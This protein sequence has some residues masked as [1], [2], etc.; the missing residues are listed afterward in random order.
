V[1]VSERETARERESQSESERVRAR[2]RETEK[3]KTP[4]RDQYH[5]PYWY[6]LLRAASAGDVLTPG[7]RGGGGVGGGER[8][9]QA[10]R[11]E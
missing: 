2:E 7:V 11:D 9:I 10:K 5:V 6:S 1:C 8:F 4:Y 3:K